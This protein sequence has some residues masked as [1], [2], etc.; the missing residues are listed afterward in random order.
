LEGFEF[1]NY[2]PTKHEGQIDG[3]DSTSTPWSTKCK[4]I[5]KY[6]NPDTYEESSKEFKSK[7][8][9]K[10]SDFGWGL[11]NVYAME[12]QTEKEIKYDFH[13]ENFGAV[14]TSHIYLA[15]AITNNICRDVG[16]SLYMPKDLADFT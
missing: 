7:F 6:T 13:R 15:H 3:S 11:N 12:K 4:P 5:L 8:F 1:I 2:H 9:K 16:A 14:A 10:D